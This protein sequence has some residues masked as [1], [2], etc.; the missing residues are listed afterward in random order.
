MPSSGVPVFP[1]PQHNPDWP[2]QAWAFPCPGSPQPKLVSTWLAPSR[3]LGPGC[4]PPSPHLQMEGGLNPRLWNW[5]LSH[6]DLVSGRPQ[7]LLHLQKIQ[8][9]VFNAPSSRGHTSQRF[10]YLTMTEMGDTLGGNNHPHRAESIYLGKALAREH[11]APADSFSPEETRVITPS[12]LPWQQWPTGQ[13]MHSI[14]SALA[15]CSRPLETGLTLHA[16]CR[17]QVPGQVSV[18]EQGTLRWE[19]ER[20]WP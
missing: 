10:N 2:S 17:P 4:K 14:H 12:L 20:C 11:L 18:G 9:W 13:T 16:T 7:T 1:E 19:L 15:P 5:P 6:S 8:T 3:K